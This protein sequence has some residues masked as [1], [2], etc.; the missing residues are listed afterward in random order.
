MT[1]PE[2]TD[3]LSKKTFQVLHLGQIPYIRVKAFYE[4]TL[5]MHALKKLNQSAQ[6]KSYPELPSFQRVGT[7][8]AQGY[9]HFLKHDDPSILTDYFQNSFNMMKHVRD[10]FYPYAS[11]IDNLRLLLDEIWDSGAH[12]KTVNK[13]KYF[14]GIVRLMQ[15]SEVSLPPHID[16]YLSYD[17][18]MDKTYDTQFSANIYIDTPQSNGQLNLWLKPITNIASEQ[19]FNLAVCEEGSFPPDPQ[20]SISPEQGDLIIFNASLLHSVTGNIAGSR[21]S[22]GLFIGINNPTEPL[23]FWS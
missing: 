12:L 10:L 7:P 2:F 11:P 14:A 6:L 20:F 16:R 5:C 1:E 15:N 17:P 3:S 18:N 22:L 8:F 19:K 9:E 4:P 23:E 13:Q 21:I